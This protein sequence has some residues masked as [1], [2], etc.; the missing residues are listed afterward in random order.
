MSTKNSPLAATKLLLLGTVLVSCTA[1]IS[2]QS[3]KALP[4]GQ[5]S[6]PA[7]H[8]SLTAS[9][10]DYDV[11]L[12]QVRRGLTEREMSG[13]W[14]PFEHSWVVDELMITRND[15]Y[16]FV[17]YSSY[18]DLCNVESLIALP[19][20]DGCVLKITGGDA[21]ESYDATIR[22]K[23]TTVVERRVTSGEFPEDHM[24]EAKYVNRAPKE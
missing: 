22:V 11:M 9:S 10:G 14:G 20:K 2:S 8:Q 7:R 6:Q 24:Q 16:V 1:P 13:R 5:L 12:T 23:G 4:G 19:E 3:G 18:S 21:S 17:P 15:S